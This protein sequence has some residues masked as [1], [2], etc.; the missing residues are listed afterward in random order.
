MLTPNDFDDP[1]EDRQ[2]DDEDRADWLAEVEDEYIAQ[3]DISVSE[4]EDGHDP[5]PDLD[6]EDDF[7]NEFDEA[8]HEEEEA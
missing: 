7:D 3:G 1:D 5:S 4:T 2:E 8:M 6:E